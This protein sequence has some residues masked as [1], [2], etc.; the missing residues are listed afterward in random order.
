MHIQVKIIA[1][2]NFLLHYFLFCFPLCYV[3]LLMS[4]LHSSILHN[5]GSFSTH[6][7]F[8]GKTAVSH[9]KHIMKQDQFNFP[10]FSY[11][12]WLSCILILFFQSWYHT[13]LCAKNLIVAFFPKGQNLRWIQISSE[14]AYPSK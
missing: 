4:K 8:F 13:Q 3:I 7:S 11:N 6:P 1:E 10:H 5:P 14:G 2:L 9:S 12:V